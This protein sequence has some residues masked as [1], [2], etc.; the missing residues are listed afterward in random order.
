MKLLYLAAED[1]MSDHIIYIDNPDSVE[2]VGCVE[3]EDMA[4]FAESIIAKVTK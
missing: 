2:M 3:D 1:D 4:K